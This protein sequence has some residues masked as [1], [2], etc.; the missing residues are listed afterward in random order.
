[1]TGPVERAPFGTLPGG[2][3][4][5][6]FTLVNANGVRVRAIGYGGAIVSILVPDRDGV[7]GDV[8]LGCDTLA[9]YQASEFYL[10][11]LIGRCANRIARGRF[12]LDGHEYRLPVNNGPNHLHGGPHGFHRALWDVT[13]V[14]S[15]DGA[16]IRLTYTS[17]D[18]EEGYPGTLAVQVTYTLTDADELV[19][20]FLAVTDRPTPV[21]PSQHIYWNLSGDASRDILDHELTLH[22]DAIT[23]VDADLIPT[24]ELAPVLG[25][26]FDFRSAEAI[27]ARIGWSHP[28]LEKGGGYDHNFVLRGDGL[29]EAARVRDAASGR[30][31][32]LLT[33]EPGIQLYSGNFL[34]GTTRGKGGQPLRYRT[35]LC[36]EPQ[37][38]P[39]SPNQPAFP[40]VILRP[41]EELRSR[42]VYRF[43]VE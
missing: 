33:T 6:A 38:F 16:S 24:G 8:V 42:T 17:A 40:S 3:V 18:G 9:D 13:P 1:M 30:T 41:G 14:E 11:A 20:D 10:G 26:P 43:G 39:D 19:V 22:A 37:H 36:L 15:A 34:D 7:M 23:P 31:L 2:E 25:T 35:G 12:T 5:D 28:Q 29:R 27:G 32:T 4:V 21:N